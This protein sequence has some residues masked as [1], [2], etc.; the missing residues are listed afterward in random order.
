MA[1]DANSPTTSNESQNHLL[2]VLPNPERERLFPYLQLVETPLG[3]APYESGDR[4]DHVYFPTTTI[5]SL[6]YTMDDGASAEFAVAGNE[7]IV[8]VALFIGGETMPNRRS[9]IVTTP[10][11]SNCA[12]GCF[13]V[14]TVSLHTS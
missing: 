9:A 2:R 12:A 10:L 4:L 8:G 13:S 7:G 1:K 5:V 6:L 11:T 3:M 14:S